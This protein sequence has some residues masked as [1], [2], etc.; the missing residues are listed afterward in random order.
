LPAITAAQCRLIDESREV[1]DMAQ[2][3]REPEDTGHGA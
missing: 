2:S 1:T 3:Q